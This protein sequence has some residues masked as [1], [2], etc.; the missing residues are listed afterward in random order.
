MSSGDR[1]GGKRAGK[2][3]FFGRRRSTTRKSGFSSHEDSTGGEYKV[4][5]VPALSL[6]ANQTLQ[7]RFTLPTP[8][9]RA[10]VGFGAWFI[11]NDSTELSV[12]GCVAK[13]SS[14]QHRFPAW[15]K[16]GSMWAAEPNKALA[17]ITLTFTS[18]TS[19][20][21][22]I[23][24]PVC[25]IVS[26]EFLDDARAALLRNMYAFV[27]EAL[28]ITQPGT[29]EIDEGDGTWRPWSL[30]GSERETG[31]SSRAAERTPAWNNKHVDF[32]LILKSCN[33][34]ARFLPINLWT[35]RAHLSFT[36]HCTSEHRRPCSHGGFG[37]LKHMGDGE[38]VSLDYGFQLECRFCK[39][40][41]VNAA[42]NPQRTSAQ[43]KE[44]AARRRNIELL[45]DA[46][47]DGSPQLRYRHD[48]GRE[49]ADDVFSRF[50]GQCFRCE[51]TLAPRS[52]HLDHTRPLALLWPLDGTATALCSS[53]NTEKR[54]RPPSEFY[55]DDEL[56][57][58]ARITG[59]PLKELQNPDPN[60]A[61]V[62]L[63]LSRLDWFFDVFLMRDEMQRNYD[64]KVVADNF[65][66]ALNKVLAKCPGG[67]PIDL[68]REY[69]KRRA[70]RP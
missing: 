64:G 28:F 44:D 19:T 38:R 68:V 51:E 30:A 46:L 20:T 29:V 15:D 66:K 12:D 62:A 67:M 47:L 7:L 23:Y 45:V 25:G 70:E 39:K 59:V 65:L 42:H 54:D 34:C 60:M 37:L 4:L 58:L 56:V 53:C 33:R 55:T 13:L 17:S 36:N 26:H 5:T 40:F 6:P 32:D 35:E 16:V 18:P 8:T 11:A 41:T 52:W 49:L 22:A 63:L 21:L 69:E 48:T 50:R 2:G 3:E 57:S 27:P 61:V 10:F 24:S 14:T 43:M 9:E 1:G 31:L